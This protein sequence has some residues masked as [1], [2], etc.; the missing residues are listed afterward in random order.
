MPA[1]ENDLVRLAEA[2]AD[3]SNVDWST[4]ESSART[5]DERR[6]IEQLRALAELA[7]AAR[8][9][10]S[11]WG[12]LHLRG[13]VG[14]GAFGAVL[15]AW[16][17]R[18]DR[19][20]A[21][22]LLH[23]PAAS[24]ARHATIREGR[25]LAQIRHPNVVTVFGADEHDGTVGI[26][27]EFVTG[28]TLKEIV[29]E[30]GP[31]GA[32]ESALIGR[33]LCR[34]LA[35]VHRLGFVHRD[36]KAQNV[37]REAGGRTVLMDFG[38][39][40]PVVPDDAGARILRGTPAYIAPEL[41]EGDA[42]TVRSDIYSLGVLLF[43]LVSG[44]FPVVGAS[45]DE[46]RSNHAAGRRKRL[47]DLRPDLPSGFVRVIDACTARHPAER[48]A[49]AGE[50]EALLDG[51]LT[52]DSTISLGIPQPGPSSQTWTRGGLA[53][54][55]LVLAVAAAGVSWLV[56]QARPAPSAAVAM[57]RDS[58][59]ILPFRDLTPASDDD[60]FGEGITADLIASLSALSD[61]RV[62][63]GPSTRKY[64][65]RKTSPV[66][67]GTELAVATVLDSTIRRVGDRVR[68]VAQLI[69]ARSGEQIWSGSFD[70]EA[71][72]IAAMRSDVSN[73]IAVALRGE[74]SQRD[75]DLLRPGRAYNYDAF[76]LY[77]KGRH[78]WGLRT[79]ESMNRSLQYFHEAL[80]KDPQ[81]APAY[82]GL[83]DAYTTLGLYG[84]IPRQEAY[85]RAAASAE[86]AVHLDES[87]AEGHASLGL[88]RKNRFDWQ[89]AETSFKRA[90]ELK[91]GSATAHQWYSIL[92]TQLGRFPEATAEIKIAMTLDPLS[93]A[94][95]LQF[96]S[97]LTMARRYDDAI[98]VY[99]QALTLD[100]QVATWYQH[101]ARAFAR[102]G[103]FERAAAL[104]DKARS[105]T[106]A[107]AD[108]QEMKAD[109]G[110]LYA[111]VGRARE[112]RRIADDLI[113]RHEA[114]KE[115][116]AGSIA[117]IYA[118][119]RDVDAAMVWLEKARSSGDPQ[120]GYL[121]VD[122]RWDN[123]RHDARFRTLLQSL[124][125]QPTK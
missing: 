58:V 118:A 83:A 96:A 103:E 73:R 46:L 105:L 40:E 6:A 26:W 38:A 61:L 77:L 37:M 17:P 16:D 100:G 47:T 18:L 29:T 23:A 76:N 32:P 55:V 74:L 41:L 94:P 30:Q 82:A 124:G 108:D 102:K 87:L 62:I 35:A 88:A 110:Y 8:A 66:D 67:I 22:K 20:V 106:A 39:G 43:F 64:Q 92:L 69:D 63:A 4:A 27:M 112:A 98:A 54:A 80:G 7:H 21:L 56:W 71:A 34:A 68:I 72:E 19:E 75:M 51:A 115:E 3:G 125:F 53:A 11:S 1:P 111:A 42:P 36:V 120:L 121:F 95:K 60:Y 109:L 114:A 33:D 107:G 78:Y 12:S 101:L 14:R 113:R 119:L 81:F 28:R 45:L 44:S 59:A 52:A 84:S 31:F 117:A 85:A 24:D 49:S 70:N 99:E 90:I 123:L 116:V 89:G 93:V 25:L 9:N 10:A 104:F 79:E 86:K 97:L 5:D 122:P 48:P 91:P 13:E 57:R 15:R 65:D 2:V 50:V